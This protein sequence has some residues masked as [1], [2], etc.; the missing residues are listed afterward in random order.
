G[1]LFGKNTIA[2]ALNITTAG[3]TQE[4]EGSLSALYEFEQEETI[5]S[6]VVSGPLSDTFSARLAV[7][8]SQMDAGWIENEFRGGEDEPAS[9]SSFAR[10][11]ATWDATE[12]LSFT[13]K[14]TYNDLEQSGRNS[15][16]SD[17]NGKYP[18]APFVGNMA[19]LVAPYGEFGV[20]DNKRNVGGTPG[21]LFDRDESDTDMNTFVLTA[22]YNWGDHLLTSITGYTDYDMIDAQD[23]DVTPLDILA[24]QTEEE[25]EQFSQELR[26]TSP[27]GETIDYIVGAYYQYDELDTHQMINVDLLDVIFGSPVPDVVPPGFF[28]PPI[29]SARYAHME[30]ETPSWAAFTQLT[31]NISDSFRATLGLRYANDEKDVFQELRLTEFDNR[32]SPLASLFPPASGVAPGF[33]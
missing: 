30:Q 14:Y 7:Q 4:F 8:W 26:L 12:N 25:Y 19:A 28:G 6:G 32:N 1:T 15:E 27:G 24:M 23:N 31:W 22:N 3:P 20:L 11:S 9:E 2:G 10:L 33:V 5:V 13:A 29:F 18:G 17:A 16:L 21:T